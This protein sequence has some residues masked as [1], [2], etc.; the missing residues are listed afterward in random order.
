MFGKSHAVQPHTG[1][2]IQ[3]RQ[4]GRF[5]N[6]HKWASPA[7]V[8]VGNI[9]NQKR[10]WGEA[11]GLF[12]QAEGMGILSKTVWRYLPAAY[13][14]FGVANDATVVGVVDNPFTYGFLFYAL[15]KISQ[16][17]KYE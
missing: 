15:W 17:R 14:P 16:L 4:G 11:V 7:P 9:V 12:F 5:Q 2:I 13:V 6:Q 3:P 10:P 8:H 1:S